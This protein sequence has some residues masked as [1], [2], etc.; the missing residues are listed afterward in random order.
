MS[1][2]AE[3]FIL[4]STRVASL[5]LKYERFL[6]SPIEFKRNEKHKVSHGV[7]YHIEGKVVD[8]TPRFFVIERTDM[9]SPRN[10]DYK[11][12]VC[13]N[14]TDVESGRYLIL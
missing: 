3:A 13:I 6:N 14:Y 5:P 10:S 12:I 7:Y 8:L 2:N 11:Q 4:R 9:P 1:L